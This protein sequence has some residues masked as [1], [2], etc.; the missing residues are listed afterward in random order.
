M[1]TSP[2]KKL[3]LGILKPSLE[4]DSIKLESL[5]NAKWTR[6]P[7]KKWLTLLV[8]FGYLSAYN[9]H[10]ASGGN[11]LKTAPPGRIHDFVKEHGGHT[12][13]TKV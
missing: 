10:V 4:L 2:K 1:F 7:M 5:A 13:I 12:V 8:S 9:P 11:S 3:V 6:I